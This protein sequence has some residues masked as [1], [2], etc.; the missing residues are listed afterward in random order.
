M[1]QFV[2]SAVISLLLV[3]PL[4][5]QDAGLNPAPLR[6]LPM[7]TKLAAKSEEGLGT[8]PLCVRYRA[9]RTV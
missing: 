7:T 9:V 4:H 5:P 6:I 1:G 8:L 2:A 3:V